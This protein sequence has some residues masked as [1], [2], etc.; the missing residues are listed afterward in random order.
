MTYE[1][2]AISHELYYTCVRFCGE[3]LSLGDKTTKAER[4]ITPACFALSCE[5]SALF[6]MSYQLSAMSYPLFYLCLS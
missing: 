3:L 5:P 1:P 6:A 4:D 2:S